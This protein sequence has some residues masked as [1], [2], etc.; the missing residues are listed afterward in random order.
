[1]TLLIQ[2]S[3]NWVKIFLIND[4]TSIFDI[5]MEWKLWKSVSSSTWEQLSSILVPFSMAREAFL[6]LLFFTYSW[7]NYMHLVHLLFCLFTSEIH[8][9]KRE[10]N[11]QIHTN[12]DKFY[13][14][15]LS[16]KYR[17]RHQMPFTQKRKKPKNKMNRLC[18]V[19]DYKQYRKYHFRINF[20]KIQKKY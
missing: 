11:L 6:K 19:Y 20:W 14:C 1:M 4:W 12:E 7:K 18:E 5:I 10:R 15:D 13:T 17:H 8:K 9:R 2:D 3:K 16:Q